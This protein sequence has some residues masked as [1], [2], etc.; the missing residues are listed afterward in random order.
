MGSLG[1]S[2][3]HLREDT[4]TIIIWAFSFLAILSSNLIEHNYAIYGVLARSCRRCSGRKAKSK[5][6]TSEQ[7]EGEESH[8]NRDIILLGFHK[9]AAMM[10]AHFE[11]QSPHLLEHLHVI[12]FHESI[13]PEIRKKGVTCA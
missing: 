6:D 12:D 7:A 4:L 2:F 5:G 1:I 8:A 10:L 3:G 11:H 9:I 13:M